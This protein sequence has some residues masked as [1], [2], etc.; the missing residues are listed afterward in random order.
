M[1]TP[2]P[3]PLAI[4]SLALIASAVLAGC[5]GSST[6]VTPS[7]PPT[8]ITDTQL[9]N[10]D[11]DCAEYEGQYTSTVLDIQN[12]TQFEGTLEI[13]NSNRRCTLASNNI[14]N[15]NFNDTSAN[16]ATDAAEVEKAFTITQ[17]PSEANSVTPLALGVTQAIMLNGVV[18]DLLPAAC[19]DIG[20]EPL[21]E[22]KIG[23]GQDQIDHPWRYDPMSSLNDFGTDNHNAHVQPDG[24]Y[25]YHGNPEALFAQNCS[26]QTTTSPV[27][28][29]A[30]DGFPIFGS[31]IEDDNGGIRE[32]TSSY[33]LKEGGGTRQNVDGYMTP[34]SGTGQIASDNYDGQF[35][36]DYEYVSGS[37]DLDE[38]NG[39]EVDGQYGYYV[40]SGFPWILNCFKATID[41]SFSARTIDALNVKMHGH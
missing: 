29:F 6:E 9:S 17:E 32:V 2:Y 40:T 3:N 38:C 25:H 20:N 28:G 8:D 13:D 36:G 5:G 27:I 34:T 16:F 11:G 23:C 31:C 39:M 10:R 37:G 19:Y 21:G 33:A 24:S 26:G 35:R 12:S 15:H 41:E 14:P 30:A 7:N 22:E 4:T 18:V 1:S